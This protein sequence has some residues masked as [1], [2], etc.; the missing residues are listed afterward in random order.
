M[1]IV[2]SLSARRTNMSLFQRL[3][4]FA[5]MFGV[6]G[7]FFFGSIWNISCLAVSAVSS[8]SWLIVDSILQMISSFGTCVGVTAKLKPLDNTF[9]TYWS[10]SV[11][12]IIYKFLI[13]SSVFILL[14][15]D[16]E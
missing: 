2:S 13:A 10:N 7:F 9:F 4:S 15:V 1:T 8:P 16:F 12:Q 11:C 6:S 3:I 5:V 14:C